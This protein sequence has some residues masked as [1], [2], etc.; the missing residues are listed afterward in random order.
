MHE[1]HPAPP[2]GRPAV[3]GSVLECD[4]FA[5]YAYLAGIIGKSF[6]HQ[7]LAEVRPCTSSSRTGG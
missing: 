6:F 5:V 2:G 4:D 7:P 1:P 3:I